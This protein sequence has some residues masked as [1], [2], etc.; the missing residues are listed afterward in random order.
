MEIGVAEVYNS[1]M[2]LKLCEADWVWE[3]TFPVADARHPGSIG[4]GFEIELAGIP[5]AARAL[6][7]HALS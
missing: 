6:R 4:A 2:C 3:L 5:S 7:K 1:E